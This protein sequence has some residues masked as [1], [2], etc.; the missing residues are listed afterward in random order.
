MTKLKL[1]QLTV[2]SVESYT[3]HLTTLGELCNTGENSEGIQLSVSTDHPRNS[4]WSGT[5]QVWPHHTTPHH[6]ERTNHARWL[7][8]YL[9]CPHPGLSTILK[10]TFAKPQPSCSIAV[11]LPSCRPCRVVKLLHSIMS[12]ADRCFQLSCCKCFIQLCMNGLYEWGGAS[13]GLS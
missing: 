13:Y 11:D 4:N 7:H 10:V 6:T 8:P 9:S 5:G 1:W 2:D 3:S 12:P